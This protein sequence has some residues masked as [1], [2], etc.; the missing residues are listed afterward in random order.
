MRWAICTG[1]FFLS[2]VATTAT[3]L[4][5]EAGRSL[6]TPKRQCIIFCRHYDAEGGCL[7]GGIHSLGNGDSTWMLPNVDIGISG[8]KNA[9]GATVEVTIIQANA[10]LVRSLKFVKFND[11]LVV[12]LGEKLANG[13]T[14]RVEIL[15]GAGD[16]IHWNWDRHDDGT[17]L[18]PTA[19]QREAVF[20]ALTQSGF[21]RVSCT[22]CSRLPTLIGEQTYDMLSCGIDCVQEYSELAAYLYC[23]YCPHRRGWL[24]LLAVSCPLLNEWL[25]NNRDQYERAMFGSVACYQ[26]DLLGG[27]SLV[28]NLETLG[29][30]PRQTNVGVT[31]YKKRVNG[32]WLNDQ[33]SQA[34]RKLPFRLTILPFEIGSFW[35]ACEHHAQRKGPSFKHG[36]K[37]VCVSWLTAE[38]A[39]PEFKKLPNLEE[40]LIFAAVEH[41]NDAKT[42]ATLKAVQKA[43]PKAEAHLVF[44]GDDKPGK[45]ASQKSQSPRDLGVTYDD[46]MIQTV[47]LE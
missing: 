19:A 21:A 18:S 8:I 11:T 7:T 30:L 35:S 46:P 26:I 15:I 23:G 16:V 25:S 44:Y 24:D 3:I 33:E 37:M 32:L 41:K 36:I 4:G 10:E 22:S 29:R 31:I 13:F 20:S 27:P 42:L 28:Q 47:L 39:I 45:T 2:M 17:K 43:L 6:S 14:P 12:P 9:D 1:V 38:A 5:E 34:V 40:I